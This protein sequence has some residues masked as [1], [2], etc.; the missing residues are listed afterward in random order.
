[1]FIAGGFSGYKSGEPFDRYALGALAC[2]AAIVEGIFLLFASRLIDWSWEVA[3]SVLLGWIELFVWAAVPC[4]VMGWVK[5]R[6]D[7]K[8]EQ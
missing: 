4:V 7:E 5:A 1:M 6:H 2:F 8:F 3:P